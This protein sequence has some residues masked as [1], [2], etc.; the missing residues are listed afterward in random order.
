MQYAAAASMIQP[1]DVVD[2]L[3]LVPW[4]NDLK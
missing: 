4:H 1:H 3:L 2:D